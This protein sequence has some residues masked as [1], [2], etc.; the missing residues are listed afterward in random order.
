[1]FKNL[2]IFAIVVLMIV[3]VILGPWVVIWAWNTLPITL[4]ELVHTCWI[5]LHQVNPTR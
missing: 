2:G 1:M 5:P 3:A 4:L